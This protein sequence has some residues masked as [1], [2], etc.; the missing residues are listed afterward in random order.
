[1]TRGSPSPPSRAARLRAALGR[2][3][4]HCSHV[5]GCTPLLGSHGGI[6]TMRHVD[7]VEHAGAASPEIGIESGNG[8]CAGS[9]LPAE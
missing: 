7:R 4:A 8:A 9:D 1:M 2:A 5:R 6:V 3:R